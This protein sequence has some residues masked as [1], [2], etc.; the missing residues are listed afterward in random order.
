[1]EPS[2]RGT[3]LASEE[4]G[5]RSCSLPDRDSGFYSR[6]IVVPKKD[7]SLCPILDLWALNCALKKFL[8][9]AFRGE[10]YQ[11]C[12]LSFGLALSP[13]TFT[14]CMDAAL[15]PLHL[16]VLNYLDNWLILAKSKAMVFSHQ[17]AVLAR[18]RSVGLKLNTKKCMLSLS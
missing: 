9:F 6:Y 1:M 7:R 4:K 11:Y 3:S 13:D 15:V 16:R 8:R 10:A 12:V 17:D 14:K 18:M 2:A 5:H